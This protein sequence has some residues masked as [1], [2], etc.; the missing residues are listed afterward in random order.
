MFQSPCFKVVRPVRRLA[1]PYILSAFL[2]V[3][4]ELC[5]YRCS[6][7]ISLFLIND[8]SVPIS[9]AHLFGND[10]YV[11]L[12]TFIFCFLLQSCFFQQFHFCIFR[13]QEL[14]H[15]NGKKKQ[16]VQVLLGLT[17]KKGNKI[18]FYVRWLLKHLKVTPSG[19]Q[20]ASYFYS[21]DCSIYLLH[22][23]SGF[24]Y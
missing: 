3:E 15:S 17:I 9:W 4:N 14:W 8:V 20:I 23:Y 21:C 10:F 24:H 12:M 7:D 11:L 5:H 22:F 2:D 6:L 16:Q 13:I 1:E 19:L 18:V